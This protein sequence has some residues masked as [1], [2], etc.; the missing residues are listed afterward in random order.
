MC[1]R[2]QQEKMKETQL[3]MTLPPLSPSEAAQAAVCKRIFDL[4]CLDRVFHDAYTEDPGAALASAGIA[5]DP[6]IR[7][8]L[9]EKGMSAGANTSP[10]SL[11]PN[12]KML[13]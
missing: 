9:P 2:G 5:A 13:G 12:Q 11:P 3:F 4:Y 7:M 8:F 10:V 6:S 1:R